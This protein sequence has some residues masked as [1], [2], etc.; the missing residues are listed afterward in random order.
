M[1]TSFLGFIGIDIIFVVPSSAPAESK[2]ST[3]Q[4]HKNARLFEKSRRT[5]YSGI[6]HGFLGQNAF[7]GSTAPDVSAG[8]LALDSLLCRAF[9]QN[10]MA[11]AANSS[12]TVTGSLGIHTRF[13][14]ALAF[15]KH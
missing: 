8:F 12:M 5:R 7:S 1:L 10:A 14:F 3:K 9:S 6:K 11:V 13:P 15:A 2:Q 4:K